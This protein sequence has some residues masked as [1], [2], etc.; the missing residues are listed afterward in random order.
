ATP[1]GRWRSGGSDPMRPARVLAYPLFGE[2]TSTSAERAV[3]AERFA[4]MT[5][6]RWNRLYFRCRKAMLKARRENPDAIRR[7]WIAVMSRRTGKNCFFVQW[8]MT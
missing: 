5:P 6:E 4:Y 7:R 3:L 8:V 2:P 1:G